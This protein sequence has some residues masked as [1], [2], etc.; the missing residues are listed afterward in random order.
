[1]PDAFAVPRT[2]LERLG[3]FDEVRFPFLYD[4]ADLNARLRG[5]G[6]TSIVVADAKLWHKVEMAQGELVRAYENGGPMRVRLQA[7]SR[8]YFHRRHSKGAQRVIATGIFIPLHAILLVA[9]TLAASR[10]LGY[11]CRI[12]ATFLKG[13]A[14]GYLS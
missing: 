12:A 8:V 2:V 7:R 11:R 5:I 1:M 3:G 13:L 9:S 6:L 14:E 4:E 10:P